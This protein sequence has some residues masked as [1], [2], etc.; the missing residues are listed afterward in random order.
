MRQR[1]FVHVGLPKSGTTYLQAV[2]GANRSRLAEHSKL[3][4]PGRNWGVQVDAVR[5]LLEAN[6]HGVQHPRTEGAWSRLVGDIER[7]RGDAVISM[8]WLCSA[9]P[10]QARRL[11]TSFGSRNVEIIVTTRDL[12]RTIPAAWQEFMRNWETDT[13]PEFVRAISADDPL[14]VPLGA[15]FW[16]QQDIGRVLANWRDV[17]DEDHI[18]VVTLPPPGQATSELWQR[19]AS[20]LEIDPS[21]YDASGR[22][23]NE[24]VGLASS[25]LLRRLNKL[26]RQQNLPW[27]SYADVVKEGLAKRGLAP[28]RPQEPSL[29]IPAALHGWVHDQAKRQRRTIEAAGVHVVGDLADLEPVLSDG[30]QPDQLDESELVDAAVDGLLY[31]TNRMS[32]LREANSEIVPL[33]QRVADLEAER[34]R[35][36]R[37]P[38]RA[39]LIEATERHR[40]LMALRKVYWKA[41]NAGRRRRN[42][43]DQTG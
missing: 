7:W 11:V 37:H 25:E 26:S 34:Q 2:L 22:A 21:R 10:A 16:K 23:G 41:A 32:R 14:S 27:Q 4:Y 40:S 43:G 30:I 33:K 6:P 35:R 19:F 9:K 36:R 3:L 18:H 28:R 38:W 24:S 42:R 31:L 15:L 20:V 17:V 39:A 13:W 1:V 29:A 5:D 8:E 12:G